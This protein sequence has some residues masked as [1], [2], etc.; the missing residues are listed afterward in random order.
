[1][2]REPF[3]LQTVKVHVRRAAVSSVSLAEKILNFSNANQ[4]I[5]SLDST[6]I[7]LMVTTSVFAHSN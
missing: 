4:D 3:R 5:P 7:N 6:Q 1:M 2:N